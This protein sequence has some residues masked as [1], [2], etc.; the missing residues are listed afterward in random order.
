MSNYKQFRAARKY[1]YRSGLEIKVSDYLKELKVDFG[2]ENLK[3]EWTDL[4]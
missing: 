1:G 3:I 4:A 2:Y